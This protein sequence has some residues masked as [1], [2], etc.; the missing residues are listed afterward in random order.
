MRTSRDS[1]TPKPCK[2][3]T[4]HALGLQVKDLIAIGAADTAPDWSTL[5]APGGFCWWYL[6]LVNSS[7]DGL[8]LIWS[9]GLPFLPGLARDARRG[10][11]R[12][13]QDHP[14]LN[15]AVY[16]G[17][18]CRFYLLQTYEPA[19]PSRDEAWCRLGAS[20]LESVASPGARTV[21]ARLDLTLPDGRRLTGTVTAAGHAVRFDQRPDA[22][23]AGGH[24]WTPLLMAATGHAELAID[25]AAWLSLT[26]HAY[27]DRNAC[28]VPLHELGCAR[29]IWG[30]APTRAGER[31][32][33][34][35][36]R[37]DGTLT[38]WGIS[39]AATGEARWTPLAVQA[40]GRRWSWW[41]LRWPRRMQL[42]GDGWDAQVSLDDVLDDGPFY[43]R[44]QARYRE[45][46]EESVGVGELVVPDRIDRGWHR[47]LV[48]MAV[49]H[50]A[51]PNSRWLP[52]FAGEWP[53]RARWFRRTQPRQLPG[54]AP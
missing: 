51:A 43:L 1:C 49:H 21:T 3:H 12:S 16:T 15:L 52:L 9:Y 6:D 17:G 7:G 33:Y 47:P 34:L 8:V 5:E 26:G 13:P 32:W 39:V 36:W 30:R 37:D 45:G 50:T 28:R 40:T 41:G 24:S 23:P 46:Q 48:A 38:A 10:T 29:W 25:G 53:G 54:A 44:F 14:S 27:H 11:P 22:D 31:V 20:T 35:L 18:E 19:A 2:V 42:T 4:H